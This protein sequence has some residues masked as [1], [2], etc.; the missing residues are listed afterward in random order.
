MRRDALRLGAAVAEQARRPRMRSVALYRSERLVDRR[1]NERMDEPERRL[2]AHHVRAR[3]GG[4]RLRRGVPIQVGELRRITWFGV[5]A[6]DR[7]SLGEPRGAPREPRQANR[8]RARARP[9]AELAQAGHVRLRG[10]NALG[11]EFVHEVAQ[12]LRI[13]TRLRMARRTEGGVGVA[14]QRLPYEPGDGLATRRREPK[15]RGKRVGDESSEHAGVRARLSRPQPYGDH[16]AESLRTR[17]EA[18]QP[19]QRGEVRPVQVVEGEQKR[20]AGSHVRGQPVEAVE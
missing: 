14:R 3:E 9:R 8:Y 15:D 16:D 20:P 10:E 5:V 4:S 12:E 17:Q 11:R 1:T 6:E 19:A 2:L 18:G 7:D 13:S